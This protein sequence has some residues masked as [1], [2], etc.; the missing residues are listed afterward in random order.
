MVERENIERLRSERLARDRE[1]REWGR[2]RER[3]DIERNR[4]LS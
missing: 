3:E 2:M 4:E 1:E